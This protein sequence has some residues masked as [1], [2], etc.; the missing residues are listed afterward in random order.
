[1]HEST[2]TRIV[3]KKLATHLYAWKINARYAPGVP[4]CWYSGPGGS[5]WV[6]WKYLHKMPQQHKPKLSA[7]QRAWLNA[8]YDE[9]RKV[10]VL[11]G[12][13]EGIAVYT[14]KSWEEVQPTTKLLSRDEAARWIETFIL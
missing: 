7:L 8:R 12:S 5:L 14:D 4:D 3:N 13:P 6:E 11:V 2:F 9:G 10:A 1:M